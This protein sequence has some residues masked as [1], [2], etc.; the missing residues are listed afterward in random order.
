MRI[1]Q[2]T[3]LL[4]PVV[5]VLALL[6]AACGSE[7]TPTPRPTPT[8]APVPT[9]TSVPTATPV[10]TLAPGVTPPPPAPTP[11]PTVDT[12]AIFQAEWDE[13]V[14]AAQDEG[15]VVLNLG[16]GA[17]RSFQHHLDTFEQEFG[18]S[19]VVGRG[20]AS[21]QFDRILAER[22]N[23]IFAVD[24]GHSGATSLNPPTDTGRRHSPPEAA[25]VRADGHR[26]IALAQRQALLR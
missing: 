15:E 26:R 17:G 16:G 20:R 19:L 22:G 5:A 11:T 4:L 8:S 14:A 23:G 25:A 13:L 12:Q 9:A 10:P 2:F 21:E 1:R 18:I 24:V 6:A 7:P 3:Q